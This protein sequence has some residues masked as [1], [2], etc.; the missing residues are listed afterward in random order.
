[1][2][3]S[4]DS[5]V[6]NDFSDLLSYSTCCSFT[7]SIKFSSLV[8]GFVSDNTSLYSTNLVDETRQFSSSS[9][10]SV[11]YLGLNS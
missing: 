6:A 7:S 4:I 5:N 1:M 9:L 10:I 3:S 2:D 8:K 11:F